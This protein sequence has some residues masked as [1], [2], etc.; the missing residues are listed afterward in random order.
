MLNEL[1]FTI[2]DW[3]DYTNKP[4]AFS[5]PDNLWYRNELLES[6]KKS[7][8]K[9]LYRLEQMFKGERTETNVFYIQDGIAKNELQILKHKSDIYKLLDKYFSIVPI[10]LMNY[11]YNEDRFIYTVVMENEY[12]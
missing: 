9:C 12:I 3:K 1:S 6:L 10:E 5:M 8:I 4:I 11:N 2:G 7:E